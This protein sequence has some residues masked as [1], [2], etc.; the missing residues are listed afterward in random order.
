MNASLTDLVRSICEE[1]CDCILIDE[2]NQA[3]LIY[4]QKKWHQPLCSRLAQLDAVEV[5][6]H[7]RRNK[8]VILFQ[9][10][11]GFPDVDP[12]DDI[13]FEEDD[14]DEIDI[15]DWV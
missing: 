3:F 2:E 5:F 1:F 7:K 9:M 4:V 10:L 6:R 11:Q 13:F 8:H 12:T 15:D 14:D